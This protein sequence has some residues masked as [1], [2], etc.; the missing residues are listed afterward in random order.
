MVDG[1]PFLSD[2]EDRA[3]RGILALWHL[4]FPQIERELK[5]W[6]LLHIEYGILAVLNMQPDRTLQLGRLAALAGMSPSRLTHRLRQLIDRGLVERS[7]SDEDG[8]VAFARLTAA[9]ADLVAAVSP[10]HFAQVRAMIF[11]RLDETQ[12]DALAD[13]MGAVAAGLTDEEWWLAPT[14]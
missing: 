9:G 3:W 13:A 1:P 12:V 7:D 14:D 10:V 8:R 6:G 4:G 2:T 11:D 5:E